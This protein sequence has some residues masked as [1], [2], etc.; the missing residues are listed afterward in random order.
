M[1][2]KTGNNGKVYRIKWH[3]PSNI[4]LIKY[5]GKRAGQLPINPSLSFTLSRSFTETELIAST[6]SAH[7]A[8]NLIFKLDGEENERFA[9]RIRKYMDMNQ[10]HFPTIRNYSLEINSANTFPHS[11]GIASSASGMSALVLCLLSLEWQLSTGIVLNDEFYKRASYLS[12]LASGSACRSL[13][14]GFVLWG[15]SVT[16]PNSS[17]E[18]GILLGENVSS[19]F[20]DYRDTILILSSGEKSTSSSA[21]HEAMKTHPFQQGRINQ[22]NQ[23]LDNLL[24]ILR[25]D[26]DQAFANIAENEA[27]SLHSL[28]LSSNPGY[29]L[30][31]PETLKVIEIIRNFRNDTGLAVS[32]TLDAGPNVHLL[33]HKSIETDVRQ[34]INGELVKFCENGRFIEDQVGDG[35]KLIH[36]EIY[37]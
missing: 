33:Y 28:M 23:N 2:E 22:A 15:S 14:G 24:E 34:L 7:D 17:D 31:K 35:P 8:G 32:F 6:K 29:F 10:E 5:W 9:L 3:S 21:G 11:S 4:A 26:N 37:E 1:S 18:Y 27:L 30:M 16:L 13:Y 25:S 36:S 12:R 19:H 20:L